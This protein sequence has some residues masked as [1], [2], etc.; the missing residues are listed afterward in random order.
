M[1]LLFRA[2]GDVDLVGGNAHP[3]LDNVALDVGLPQY[4]V[5]SFRRPC[6]SSMWIWPRRAPFSPSS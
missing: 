5:L 6:P 4:I 3:I 1:E 2:D